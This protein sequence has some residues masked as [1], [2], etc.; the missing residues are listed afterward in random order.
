MLLESSQFI[1]DINR[2][3]IYHRSVLKLKQFSLIIFYPSTNN[4]QRSNMS[5]PYLC[6][7]FSFC[8]TVSHMLACEIV[9][10]L[11]KHS[12]R[13]L[14]TREGVY[15]NNWMCSYILVACS[16]CLLIDSPAVKKIN[17]CLVL[18]SSSLVN[19]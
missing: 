6:V 10:Y 12:N 17:G 19:I 15:K 18:V 2:Q 16:L 7:F 8:F 11:G 4:Q 13:N 9:V 3:D 14:N 5:I 1:L